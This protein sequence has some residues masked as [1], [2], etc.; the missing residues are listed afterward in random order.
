MNY[1]DKSLFFNKI[2]YGLLV[3]FISPVVFFLI[4][5]IFRFEQY[6]FSEYIRILV[7]SKKLVNVLSL[8]VL[9]NLGPFM[10]FINSNRYSSGRGVLAATIILGIVIFILK[11][12]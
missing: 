11:L 4:Y 3:G 10:L 5:Y 6:S 9:P 12:I 1:D 7:E 8:T 2:I